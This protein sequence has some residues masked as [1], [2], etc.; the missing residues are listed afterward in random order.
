MI[1]KVCTTF[2]QRT[3]HGLGYSSVVEFICVV[4]CQAL[5]LIPS[6]KPNSL[7]PPAAPLRSSC[8]GF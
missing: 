2:Y 4:L 3:K 8:D 6:T 1:S 5:G 7:L